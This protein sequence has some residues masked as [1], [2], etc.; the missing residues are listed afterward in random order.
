MKRLFLLPLIALFTMA[1]L[2]AC[3]DDPPSFQ[4]QDGSGSMTIEDQD[5][6]E[7]DR[8]SVAEVYAEG[9]AFI[10]IF[11]DEDGAPGEQVGLLAI[12]AGDHSDREVLLDRDVDGEEPFHAAL[13]LDTS[14]LG[15][16]DKD[17]SLIARDESGNRVRAQ[18]TLN[19]VAPPTPLIAASDQ[20]ADPADEVVVDEVLS[21]GEGWIVVHE[22]DDGSHGAAIG[23]ARVADGTHSDVT[24]TLDRDAVDGETLHAMLHINQ[25]PV[26]EYTD[27]DI[28]VMV[29]DEVVVASFT[30]SVEEEEP[31]EP[32]VTASVEAN[33]Q[34]VSTEEANRVS[35]ASASIEEADGWIVIHADDA[36]APGEVLGV[37]F[38]EEGSHQGVE[39][40]LD[41]DLTNDALLHAMIHE[42]DP[43][44]GDYTFDG[45]NG[46]DLPVLDEDDNPVMATF[47]TTLVDPN[48]PVLTVEDQTLETLPLD[49]IL[50]L[51]VIYNQS[52][53]VVITDDGDNEI[54]VAPITEDITND[55]LIVLDRDVINGEELTATL[56]QNVASGSYD[57]SEDTPVEDATGAVITEDFVV[58][59]LPY[60][61][62]TEDHLLDELSTVISV[63]E[64]ST[65]GDVLIQ[66]FAEEDDDHLLGTS[67]TLGYGVHQDIRIVMDRPL[68]DGEVLVAELVVDDGD[69]NPVLDSNSDPVDDS[70]AVEVV[71]GTPALFFSTTQH[72]PYQF[73]VEPAEYGHL[74]DGGNN[75]D[76]TLYIGWRYKFF[77]TSATTHALELTDYDPAFIGGSEEILL[78]QRADTTGNYEVVSSVEWVPD[79]PRFRFT[80]STDLAGELTGY[81]TANTP[82]IGQ[83]RD[84][85]DIDLEE[86]PA[87][88]QR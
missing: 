87:L 75:P 45:S 43:A 57:P 14:P 38:I 5:L 78:S 22:D 68:E 31:V 77:N 16:F 10:V 13:Y 79:G 2:S 47:Q 70:F 11:E 69:R 30:V 53:W 48:A 67:Q 21:N 40:F 4:V 26:D 61:V 83:T 88:Q 34:S 59:H 76:L 50:V 36:G 44:D 66:V 62:T 39:V 7:P 1:L 41:A 42:D 19:Y 85:G 24:V 3:G 29:D 25:E 51:E 86:A 28:P 35:I 18:F 65:P 74:I 64:V 46:E 81:R 9:E 6:D 82:G 56:H 8:F 37:Q 58:S 73:T 12:E 17:D 84:R 71:D 33:D 32:L 27:Q 23:L 20:M 60:E 49:E 52:G 15:V 80:L 55:L 72:D 63:A 54:G